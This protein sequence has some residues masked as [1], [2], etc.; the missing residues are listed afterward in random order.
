MSRR[1]WLGVACLSAGIGLVLLSF[2]LSGATERACPELASL[3][4]EFLGVHLRGVRLT[5]IDLTAATIEWY[6]GCNW[7][8]QSFVPVLGGAVFIAIGGGLYQTASSQ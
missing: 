5:D 1:R 7:H 2:T 8:T 4:Y 3:S 6:D